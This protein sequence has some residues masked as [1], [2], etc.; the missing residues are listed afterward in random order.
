MGA[1][2]KGDGENPWPGLCSGI[3]GLGFSMVQTC[4][5]TAMLPG[6]EGCSQTA[7]CHVRVEEM[8]SFHVNHGGTAAA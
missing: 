5:E 2:D 7:G 6:Q 3:G 4:S 1:E 8:R